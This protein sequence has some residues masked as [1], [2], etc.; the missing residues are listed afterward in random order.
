VPSPYFL[1][2]YYSENFTFACTT[3]VACRENSD[4]RR[5]RNTYTAMDIL[6]STCSEKNSKSYSRPPA[7]QGYDLHPLSVNVTDH[8]LRRTLSG[9]LNDRVLGEY[10]D[11]RETI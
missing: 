1:I 11:L 10:L 9:V 6:G 8:P 2:F 4:G 3:L 7:K 5:E